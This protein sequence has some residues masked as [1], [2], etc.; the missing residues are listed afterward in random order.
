MNGI[1]IAVFLSFGL[2]VEI[3]LTQLAI[4]LVL[5]RIGVGKKEYY[6]YPLNLT[7]F[8][9]VSLIGAFTF[10]LL[11]GDHQSI[12]FTSFQDI[13]AIFGYAITV[14]VV[15]QLFIKMNHRVFYKRNV[16][17]FD[18]GFLWEIQSSLIVLPVGFVLFVLYTE[19]GRIAIFYMGIPFVMIAIILKLLYS[20]QEINRYLEETGEIGHQLTKKMVVNEVY[21]VFISKIANLVTMDCAY[22]YM[23][24]DEHLE[25]VRF[26]DAK[27]EIQPTH[28][29]L[30]KNEAFS[31]M[32]WEEN[33]PILYNNSKEWSFLKANKI[34]KDMESVISLP[35]ET[36]NSTIGIVTLVSKEKNAFG[37]VHLRILDILTNYFGVAIE[38]AK[39]YE[40]TKLNSEKDGLTKLY[41]YRYFNNAVEEYGSNITKS[42]IYSLILLDLDHF[43]QVNDKY[44]HEAG[45]EILRLFADT[46]TEFI[47]EKGL[48]ARYGGEEFVISLPHINLTEACKLAESLRALIAETP[49]PVMKHIFPH[50]D[51]EYV[52]VTAS[53]G[54]SAY[55]DH[56]ET[57]NE[58]IRHADRA[59]YLG[60]KQRGR[61]KVAVY[62][63]LQ[64]N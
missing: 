32:V 7:M 41:N 29:R 39:N 61:N 6:R 52:S 63:E 8:S 14:F 3:I 22:I 56:C 9:A 38:N 20:Y 26:T 35:I 47:G 37:K 5:A 62:Q 17:L 10:W 54:V 24:V 2:F 15:N 59:M 49:F 46:L 33:K 21:D 42:S 12:D 16:K 40:I 64:P 58:L 45:N 19:I 43:K 30:S 25:L 50:N 18:K 27:N 23:V 31:G 44:G 53:I 36:N 57:L 4:L 28:S 51:V 13:V 48:V 55:P 34:P 1:S 60:A 11:G